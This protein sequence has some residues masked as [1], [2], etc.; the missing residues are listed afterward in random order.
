MTRYEFEQID[1]FSD[2]KQVAYD[3]GYDDFASSIVT[4]LDYEVEDDLSDW[5]GSWSEL[6][7]CLNGIDTGH[8]YYRR[9]GSFDY[10]PI[11]DD[12][13]DWWEELRDM[14]EN[15]GDFDPEEEEEEEEYEP[16]PPAPDDVAEVPAF[17]ADIDGSIKKIHSNVVDLAAKRREKAQELP[18]WA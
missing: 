2:L 10:V 1:N 14:M 5:D 18:D 15:N 17:F 12:F 13:D 6:R 3:M 11:D 8:D 16:E 7:D 9:D 4:D